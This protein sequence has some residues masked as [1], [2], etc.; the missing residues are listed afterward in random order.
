MNPSPSASG[1]RPAG[2]DQPPESPG[3]APNVRRYITDE[4][5]R[6]LQILNE[7][8]A[9]AQKNPAS[10]TGGRQAVIGLDVVWDHATRRFLGGDEAT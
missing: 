4:V 3:R 10:F 9:Q 8:I 2:V 1:D 7:D 5:G 6:F